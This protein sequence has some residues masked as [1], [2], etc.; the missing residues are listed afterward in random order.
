VPENLLDFKQI[1]NFLTDF[2]KR[3]Q[4]Q[5]SQRFYEWEQRWYI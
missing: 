5:I 4:Y 2:H 3:S 1:W